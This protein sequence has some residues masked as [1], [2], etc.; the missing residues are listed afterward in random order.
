MCK[1]LSIKSEAWWKRNYTDEDLVECDGFKYIPFA[2]RMDFM[3]GKPLNV[4][5]L[6]DLYADSEVY[7]D[8]DRVEKHKKT[9]SESNNS[10]TKV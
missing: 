7:A 2:F 9:Q 1:M 8:V 4:A 3:E 5:I 10:E 6:H